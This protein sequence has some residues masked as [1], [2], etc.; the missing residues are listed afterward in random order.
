MQ[1]ATLPSKIKKVQSNPSL[2]K[3]K[4]FKSPHA[5]TQVPVLSIAFADAPK[6][7]D[8]RRRSTKRSRREYKKWEARTPSEKRNTGCSN[9]I[10]TIN[11]LSCTVIT[12]HDIKTT[13][14]KSKMTCR[15][16][17]SF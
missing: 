5:E 8:K 16:I 10:Y 2:A 4:D 1:R 14:F 15:L 6:K 9:S 17:G 3:D 7:R 13:Y 11:Q 12:Q